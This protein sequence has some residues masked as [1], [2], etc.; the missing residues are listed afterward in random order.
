MTV[1]PTIYALSTAPYKSAIGIIRISGSHAFDVYSRLSHQQKLPK[2]RTASRCVVYDPMTNEVLDKSIALLFKSPSSFTGDD[3]VELHVHGGNAI[4]AATLRAIGHISD[5]HHHIKFA[6]PGEFT[7]RAFENGKL[8]LI[9]A[10]GINDMIN[11]ETEEQRR[12]AIKVASGELS[13]LYENWRRSL[14]ECRGLLE[15]IIDFSEDASIDE[16]ISTNVGKRITDLKA[17]MQQYLDGA[18]RG[19]LL[20]SG[21]PVALLGAPNVGKSSLLNL[22]ARRPASIVSA[23]AGTTRDVIDVMLD[24]E[25][26]PVLLGDTAGLRKATGEAESQGVAR[27]QER[28]RNSRIAILVICFDKDGELEISPESLH[29][30]KDLADVEKIV[31]VNKLDLKS[32]MIVHNEEL[33]EKVAAELQCQPDEVHFLSCHTRQ[34][35][36]S[37]LLELTQALRK[38]SH[39]PFAAGVGTSERHRQLISDCLKHTDAGLALISQDV[40][41]AAEEIKAAAWEIGKLQGRSIDAAEV[42]GVIFGQFCIGK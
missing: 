21:I 31:V 34:G 7:R 39:V 18:V 38:T 12:N 25:G 14:L 2:W 27:A 5:T 10:E 35:L 41:L 8:D 24:F 33:K 36:D 9:E 23:E 22:I 19:E 13:G 16:D 15:A 4:V 30:F 37:L 29:H 1:W 40:V 17:S 42:L 20:R 28:V 3:V 11:A 6:E 26:Y 32:K